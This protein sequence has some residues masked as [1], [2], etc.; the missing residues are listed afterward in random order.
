MIITHQI[1]TIMM[2]SVG[3]RKLLKVNLLKIFLA[4]KKKKQK[5]KQKKYKK[6]ISYNKV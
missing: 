5:L 2:M 4:R 3:I 6:V 1:S